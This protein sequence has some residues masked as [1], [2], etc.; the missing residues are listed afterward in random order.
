[1]DRLKNLSV[2]LSV[3]R[4]G[5]TEDGRGAGEHA[6]IRQNE[7]QSKK[8][9]A[10]SRGARK[11]HL[12]TLR[13]IWERSMAHDDMATGLQF[14]GV[15]WCSCSLCSCEMS[16]HVWLLLPACRC[17][18]YSLY[19]F[20]LNSCNRWRGWKTNRHTLGH[21]EAASSSLAAG[22]W[23]TCMARWTEPTQSL[24]ICFSFFFFLKNKNHL[25]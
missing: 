14:M 7:K 18:Q 3:V 9:Q 20:M 13:W 8:N 6:W 22:V 2:S 23:W 25:K 21:D 19:L 16:D 15:S 10:R 1:M 12:D 24:S 17:N 11:N 4:V 5:A